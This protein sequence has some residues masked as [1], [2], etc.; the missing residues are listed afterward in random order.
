[1]SQN[2]NSTSTDNIMKTIVASTY[3]I[4]KCIEQIER[5]DSS[6]SQ[7]QLYLM[8]MMNLKVHLINFDL[9]IGLIKKERGEELHKEKVQEVLGEL[10]ELLDPNK[11]GFL[12][13]K[14]EMPI[15][16]EMQRE[17]FGKQPE[18]ETEEIEPDSLVKINFKKGK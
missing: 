16:W 2:L 15:L 18:T 13:E 5:Q 7:E 4:H 6:I 11:A 3:A 12:I 10:K 1:M 9:Y 17:A 8:K 14:E